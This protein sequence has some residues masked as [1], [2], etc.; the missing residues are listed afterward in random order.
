MSYRRP[1]V[2]LA[3]FVTV[4]V[5]LTWLV[6]VTL[7]RDVE[8]A[9]ASYSAV[10]SDVYG[11][12]DGDDVRVAGVRVGR[13]EKVD[14]DG[15]K[16]KVTFVVQRDQQ[17]FDITIASV[18]YQ[19]IVGQRYLGLS[20][21]AATAGRI[22]APG[23]TIPLERT[24]PSFDVGVVLN[25]FEPLFSTLDPAQ[26]DNLT[27]G[28][29]ASLQGDSSSIATLVQQT[30][31]LTN[32]LVGQDDNLGAAITNLSDVTGNLAQQN[33][34]L[35]SVIAQARKTVTEFDGRRPELV[36]SLGST[37]RVVQRLATVT[38]SI[39][40]S[41]NELINRQPGFAKHMNSI[42]PQLAF[43][44][45]NLPL[46]LKGI[47]RMAGSGGYVNAYLCDLNP[48]GFFPGL[49][50]IVPVIINAGTPGNPNP[51]TPNNLGWHTPRCRNMANG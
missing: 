3:L 19:N 6:Y 38:D 15:D 22:M 9:T 43:L 27:N 12:R 41:L 46:V 42:E 35:D 25:G 30:S 40:P 47:A 21:P 16:A 8:G 50:S 18:T 11:L 1:L 23:S 31:T 7:R 20:R 32:T 14:L 34:N 36:A 17:V 49:N 2:G 51:N 13:V 24:E 39:Y 37:S 5:M 33:Q 45:S 44:G 4:A 10:I 29:V 26:V 28:I 48:M